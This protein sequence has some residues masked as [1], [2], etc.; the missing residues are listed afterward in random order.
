MNPNSLTMMDLLEVNTFKLLDCSKAHYDKEII[1][2]NER[3]Y[4]FGDEDGA[5]EWVCAKIP[6]DGRIKKDCVPK[7][8]APGWYL[9]LLDNR[10]YQGCN[11]AVCFCDDRDAC[12]AGREVMGSRLWLAWGLLAVGL[13]V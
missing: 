12:N 4:E 10:D 13:L 5:I 9:H 3:R 11:G 8:E 2:V 6:S 7:R 1:Q